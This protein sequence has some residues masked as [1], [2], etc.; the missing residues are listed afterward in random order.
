MKHF[1]DS[2]IFPIHFLPIPGGATVWH[3]RLLALCSFATKTKI[4]FEL[5]HISLFY[6][7]RDVPNLLKFYLK[8]LKPRKNGLTEISNHN[9]AQIT[10]QRNKAKDQI[11]S[12]ENLFLKVEIWCQIILE[13]QDENKNLRPV[14]I[15]QMNLK[16]FRSH[17]NYWSLHKSRLRN[18]VTLVLMS[19]QVFI[20]SYFRHRQS[21]HLWAIIDRRILGPKRKSKAC[22]ISIKAIEHV[23]L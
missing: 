5:S 12:R 21:L 13:N 14:K 8:T 22:N 7:S 4:S 2:K 17:S 9:V 3:D 16:I 10:M 1:L 20:G 11:P 19:K 15:W 23:K 6:L 18:S